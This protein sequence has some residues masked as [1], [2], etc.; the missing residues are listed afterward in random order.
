MRIRFGEFFRRS[1]IP[2]DRPASARSSD[3]AGLSNKHSWRHRRTAPLLRNSV[4][5]R[6]PK[7]SRKQDGRSDLRGYCLLILAILAPALGGGAEVWAQG[8]LAL[9]VAAM[10]LLFPP[11]RSLGRCLNFIFIAVAALPLA[12]FLPRSWT[13]TPPWQSLL[14]ND[15][16]TSVGVVRTPQPWITIQAVLSFWLVLSVAYAALSHRCSEVLRPK[17]VRLYAFGIF[18]I[19]LAYIGSFLTRRHIPS[20][21]VDTQFF[22]FFGNHDITSH[23]MAMAG[24]MICAVAVED[25]Q[26]GR[27]K[28]AVWLMPLP[29][30][31]C[32]LICNYSRAGIIL[33]FGGIL[34][35][36]VWSA[37]HSAPRQPA[38]IGLNVAIV[39]FGLFFVFGGQTLRRF[40]SETLAPFSA[41][42]DFRIRLH[43][44]ALALSMKSPLLGIGLGNFGSVFQM[45][46]AASA[47]QHLA[48][49]PESDWL[50]TAVELGWIA[51]VLLLGG[52]VLYLRR[53]FPLEHGTHACLRIAAIV[54]VLAFALHSLY[55]VPGHH[56]GAV[57]PALFL[58][59]TALHP[60]HTGIASR[61][62][63]PFFRIV[64]TVLALAGAWWL[65]SAAGGKVFPTSRTVEL[66]KTQVQFAS[67]RQDFD[68]AISRITDLLRLTPLDAEAHSDLSSAY[69]FTGRFRE[70]DAAFA[71]A[72]ALR[73][74]SVDLCLREGNVWYSLEEWPRCRVAWEAALRRDPAGAPQLYSQLLANASGN[75]AAWD[76]LRVWAH[77][78][79]EM[80]LTYVSQAGPVE[81]KVELEELLSTD[82]ELATFN[83]DQLTRFFQAWSKFGDQSRMVREIRT[84]PAWQAVG[85]RWSVKDYV[86]ERN[87]EAAYRTAIP[88]VTE[89][90]LPSLRSDSLP[91][92]R[93]RLVLFPDDIV[94][95]YQLY[96]RDAASGDL[97]EALTTLC[98]V[99]TIAGCPS[100]FHYLKAQMLARRDRWEE[101]WGALRAYAPDM[102]RF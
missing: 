69:A 81:F 91:E 21:P 26:R 3:S 49:Q 47:S 37:C 100:Y 72:R 68:Q 62:L 95:A 96:S 45:A 1:P 88:H 2:L 44:D 99:T 16:P 53:C 86:A 8:V 35:F 14:P 32:A 66:L 13:G 57:F 84:H 50:W 40:S 39:L 83:P 24:I 31:L 60:K 102:D 12:A 42:K 92:I 73:P 77:R 7:G 75:I 28:G 90:H 70:A 87:F 63:R 9:G 61:S 97:E 46:R 15:F 5:E 48:L 33:F 4:R 34:A 25:F 52:G 29:V 41:G 101:A 43:Q 10:L 22:G 54:S 67:A 74:V 17:A 89:P 18:S 65:A 27:G 85:W 98:K 19:T 78:N 51:P 79:S 93:Q 6:G 80:F 30:I 55:S 71:A 56:L 64:G 20:W 82:P 11:E 94:A 38:I 59:S 58:A 36:L 23:V 76:V